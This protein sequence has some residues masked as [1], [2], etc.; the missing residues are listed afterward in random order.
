MACRFAKGGRDDHELASSILQR[1]R[2]TVPLSMEWCLVGDSKPE[3]DDTDMRAKEI[4][5]SHLPAHFT[6][7]LT[8]EA[9]ATATMELA[10][11]AVIGQTGT[12]FLPKEAG[13]SLSESMFAIR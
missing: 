13:T 9:R 1:K 11:T 6:K 7:P 5:R 10:N 2:S 4:L 12:R 3:I 8:S